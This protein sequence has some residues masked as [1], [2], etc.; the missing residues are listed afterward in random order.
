MPTQ[1][2]EPTES[3]PE[4]VR[5]VHVDRAARQLSLLEDG[6]LTHSEAIGIGRGGLADKTSMSDFITPTGTFTVDLVLH[7]AGT[8]NAVAPMTVAE[9]FSPLLADLEQLFANMSSLDFDGDGSP[10]SAYGDAYIGLHSDSAVT[11][12]K[13]RRHSGGT[14]YW[15]SIALHG[16][17]PE[18]LG[19]ANS[20]GCVHV[21]GSL[22]DRLIRDEVLALGS[23]VTISDAPPKAMGEG[24]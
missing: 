3:A 23:T 21:D 14:P 12:P 9:E 24:R 2:V 17:V 1:D 6:V 15:Y 5:A 8:H 7:A 4:T 22:L 18:N 16:T 19:E 13:M 10:D 11:G 20:G